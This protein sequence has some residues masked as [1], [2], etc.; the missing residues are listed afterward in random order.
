MKEIPAKPW[1]SDKEIALFAH[2]LPRGGRALEFGCGGST[3][4]FFEQG[5]QECTSVEADVA[6]GQSVLAD[7]FLSFFVTKQ[8][9]RFIFPDIG[10]VRE[11]ACSW[12][13]GPPSP[14]WLHYHSDVWE[15]LDCKT[16]DFILIDGRFRVAC[17]LQ[18]IMHCP[19]VPVVLVHDFWNRKEY[20]PMLRVM[21]VQ[22]QAD[23][24]VILRRKRR[25]RWQDME[26]LLQQAMLD[27]R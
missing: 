15:R 11:N 20:R 7:P 26:K 13:E 2:W 10:L 23:T 17:A 18:S 19:H 9:L 8:R 3:R 4:F 21:D 25:I 5:I 16:L 14:L 22:D 1:M 12:P 6:W 24:A 27:P